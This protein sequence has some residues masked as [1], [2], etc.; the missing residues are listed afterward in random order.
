MMFTSFI[1]NPY[2]PERYLHFISDL[3]HGNITVA[4]RS[5]SIG[6]EVQ[7]QIKSIME[8][9]SYKNGTDKMMIL[10]IELY[11]ENRVSRARGKLRKFVAKILREQVYEAALVAFYVA[12]SENWCFSFITTTPVK[13][14]SFLL[15]R[16][17]PSYTAK[18][19]WHD[20]LLSKSTPTLQEME[21]VFSVERM[22]KEFFEKY[23][24]K[25]LQLKDHL[26]NEEFAKKVLGQLSFLYFLQKKGWLGVPAVPEEIG[27]REWD[28]IYQSIKSELA[29]DVFV[30]AFSQVA[31]DR[32]QSNLE[33]IQ[34]LSNEEGELLAQAFQGTPYYLPFGEGDKGFIRTL[35]A[36]KQQQNFYQDVLEPLFSLALNQKRGAS[37]YFIRFNCRIP[38]LNGGVF[39]PTRRQLYIP[40]DFFSNEA[41][42]GILDIF[43]LYNFT[44]NESEPFDTE[45]AID[46]EMMGKVFENLLEVK[47]RKSKGAFYTPREIVH[48]MCQESLVNYV[49]NQTGIAKEDLRQFF[50]R[51]ELPHAISLYGKEVDQALQQVRIA[52]PA[53]GSG[54]FPLGMLHE[55]VKARLQLCA[56]TPYQ[57]KVETIKNSIYAVD[58]ERSAVEITKLR[59]WLSLIVD[60]EEDAAHPLPNLDFNIR[61]GNSLIEEFEGIK[62]FDESTKI[63]TRSKSDQQL[64]LFEDHSGDILEH[65]FALQQQLFYE[66]DREKKERIKQKVEKAEWDFIEYKL[67][68]D[69]YADAIDR[70]KKYQ[71]ESKPYFLWRLEFAKVFKEKDG[72]DIV[73]GNPPYG[74]ELSEEQRKSIKRRLVDTRNL[75]TAAVFLDYSKNYLLNKQGILSF[76]VP[77]SLLYSEK[78]FSLVEAL[79]EN[80]ESLIDVEKAFEKVKLEQVV[81][82]Y[83]HSL[84]TKSYQAKKFLDKQFIRENVISASLVKKYKAW[85]CDVTADELEISRRLDVEVDYMKDIS[86][87]KRGAGLQKFLAEKG[88]YPVLG[89]K[90]IY[91]FGHV[92]NKGYLAKEVIEKHKSKLA[93]MQ[94]PKILSQDLIAH[95]QN[96]MPHIL[97]TSFYDESG[98]ILSLDTVQNTI[99]TD[100]SYDLRYILGL[101]N[102]N[103]VS[104]YTYR[105]IYCSAIRTMHFDQNYIGRI[106]I[107]KLS[108]EK[109]KP[110]I[111]LVKELERQGQTMPGNNY[112]QELNQMVYQL[113]GL[114]PQDMRVIESLS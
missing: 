107:P 54:A 11:Q 98:E 68:K 70:V 10:A 16:D 49:T 25:Y 20:L 94:N 2:D 35:F 33:A 36:Q 65:L 99:L 112:I 37:H 26:D 45:V 104:W 28:A 89:G 17:E 67:N 63:E 80:T 59:L 23:K 13:R 6:G 39:E 95:I 92:G 90:N 50:S 110:I 15:G 75:N 41:G 71:K 31:G 14:Y 64:S 19:Q 38:F 32:W 24:E 79:V 111:Q 78:W 84:K 83:N 22:T 27:H 47:D 66:Q 97:L 81:F 69:G 93:F 9:A 12:G 53:V 87:T 52:D 1:E 86:T 44:M 5:H 55:I 30:R 8:V 56:L 7:D 100:E 105:F 85:I 74:A 51:G 40:D 101:L 91:R 43:D 82:V 109:Q 3:F 58:I 103:F 60:D 113:F 42:T 18:K 57:L 106:I 21:A 48:Y 108:K 72:F 46:P 73:I 62:L 88:D 77:K 29:R 61:T 114:T 34:Q 4:P 102:S 76:I 96:P